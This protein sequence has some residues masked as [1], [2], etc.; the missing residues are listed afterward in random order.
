MMDLCGFGLSFLDTA[1]LW[2]R[3]MR[4]SL[5]HALILPALFAYYIICSA[6]TAPVYAVSLAYFAIRMAWS[7]DYTPSIRGFAW[8]NPF[9]GFLS[10]S[11][12]EEPRIR[13]YRSAQALVVA[14]RTKKPAG[15]FR[16]LVARLKSYAFVWFTLLPLFYVKHINLWVFLL[17]DEV[18]STASGWDELVWRYTSH[19]F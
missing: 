7:P 14:P 1:L 6:I 2:F 4:R 17:V 3:F 13:A 9:Q 10:Y 18:P 15:L 8:S 5:R 12:A 19:E 16:A 11:I